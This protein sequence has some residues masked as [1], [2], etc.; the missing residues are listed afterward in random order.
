MQKPLLISA[1]LVAALAANP[2]WA[3]SDLMDV[4]TQARMADPQLRAAEYRLQANRELDNQAFAGFL[5]SISG[6]YRVERGPVSFR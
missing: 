3:A 1:G 5:P 4:Y 6:G 2:A